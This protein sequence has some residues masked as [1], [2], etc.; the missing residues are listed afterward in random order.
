M[1]MVLE[2]GHSLTKRDTLSDQRISA[3]SVVHEGMKA[4]QIELHI[5]GAWSVEPGRFVREAF[6]R[7]CSFR[8]IK[9]KGHT[10]F[11]ERVKLLGK[12]SSTLKHSFKTAIGNV[13]CFLGPFCLVYFLFLLNKW[14]NIDLTFHSEVCNSGKWSMVA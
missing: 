3:D 13:P 1:G 4:A 11:T 9:F 8:I 6:K 10:E 14:P 12:E 7:G 5:H 2:R